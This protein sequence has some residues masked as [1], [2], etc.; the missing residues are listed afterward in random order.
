MLGIAPVAAPNVPIADPVHLADVHTVERYS[1]DTGKGRME[2]LRVTATGPFHQFPAGA[3][4]AAAHVAERVFGDRT[5]NE[6]YGGTSVLA[7]GDTFEAALQQAG[8]LAAPSTVDDRHDFAITQAAKGFDVLDFT[9]NGGGWAY[10]ITKGSVD[11]TNFTT[12]RGS[13]PITSRSTSRFERV[14]PSLQAL[15]GRDW[16]GDMNWIDFRGGNTG[17][18]QPLAPQA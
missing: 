12:D 10:P 14:D 13:Y 18:L 15:V 2:E 5:T 6:G 17:T 1:Q 3:L 8:K 4:G 16:N 7:H 11:H 9:T